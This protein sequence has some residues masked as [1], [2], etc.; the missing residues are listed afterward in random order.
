MQITP[1]LTLAAALLMAG[2]PPPADSPPEQTKVNLYAAGPCAAPGYGTQP[3]E[4]GCCQCQPNCCDDVWAG[5]CEK[6]RQGLALPSLRPACRPCVPMSTAICRQ[7]REPDCEPVATAETELRVIAPP[8]IDPQPTPAPQL[9]VAP[10]PAP[11][12]KP[13]AAPEPPLPLPPAP[14]P[15]S[16]TTESSSPSDT[17]SIPFPMFNPAAWKIGG[18]AR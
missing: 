12:P 17:T 5:Y 16:K 11:A 13:E 15:G 18:L 6:K 14:E 4:P 1:I 3:L 10:L 8:A 7:C 9:E 2:D